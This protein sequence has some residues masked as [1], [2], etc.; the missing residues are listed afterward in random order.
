MPWKWQRREETWR[1][2]LKSLLITVQ[3][4]LEMA[5]KRK[6]EERNRISF[7]NSTKCPGNGKEEKTWRG[8]TE[9]LLITAQND[10]EMAKKRKPEERNW[11]SL[12]T[13]QNYLEMAKKRK[14]EERNRISFNNSTKW[15][16]NGKEE[17]TWREKL[18]LF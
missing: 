14:P 8:E 1:E 17:K 5:K 7:N 4:A 2:K 13:T 11:I 10:L 16:G 6:P 3:N 15:P 18:N 12:I 9:S